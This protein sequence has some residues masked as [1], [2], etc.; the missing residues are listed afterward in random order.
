MR[1]PWCLLPSFHLG[2]P[3]CG[4]YDHRKVEEACRDIRHCGYCAFPYKAG[5][6]L[7]CKVTCSLCQGHHLDLRCGKDPARPP[8][9]ARGSE[10]ARKPAT[11]RPRSELDAASLA[12]TVA[13][14]VAAALLPAISSAATSGSTLPATAAPSAGQPSGQ[15]QQQQK[16]GR[17]GRKPLGI[18]K[19]KPDKPSSTKAK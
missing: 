1:D 14:S 5:H 12:T 6:Y 9:R 4:L 15:Q 3:R 10:D 11:K 13:K 17:K 18:K 8:P 2:V 7:T 16:R 19:E